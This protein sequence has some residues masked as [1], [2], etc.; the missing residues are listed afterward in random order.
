MI[1]ISSNYEAGEV[2]KLWVEKIF[3]TPLQPSWV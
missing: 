2:V 1:H 3:L